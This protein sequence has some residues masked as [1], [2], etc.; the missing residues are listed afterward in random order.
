MTF[1]A[2]QSVYAGNGATFSRN[3]L[4]G[5]TPPERGTFFRLHVY[6]RVRISPFEAYEMVGKSVIAVCGR[7]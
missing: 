5:E 7:T 2:E 3:G 6:K 4:H 1:V